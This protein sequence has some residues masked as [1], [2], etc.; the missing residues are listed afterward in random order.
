MPN[1]I[2]E[3]TIQFFNNLKCFISKKENITTIENVPKSFEELFGKTAPYHLSF[4]TQNKNTEFVGKGSP[5]LSAITKFLEKAGKTTLLKIDFSI[6]P[7]KE[8]K[9]TISLK[10]CEIENLTRK[11]KNNFF[12]RFTFMTTFRHLN[13][14]EQIINEIYVHDGEIVKGDLDGYT[15]IEGKK[16][17]V[18][19]KKIEQDYKIAH[20]FLKEILNEKTS[21]IKKVLE[22][23]I[24]NEIKRIRT[25]YE[26]IL[27][28]LGGDLSGTIKKIQENELSLRTADETETATLKTRLDRLRKSLLKMGNDDSRDRILKE[29]EFTIKDAMHKYSLNIDNKLINTTLIY[30]PIFHFNLFLK[31]DSSSR[32]VEMNYNPLTKTLNELNCESCNNKLTKINLCSAGHINCESC[33]EKCGECSKTFCKKC[34]K[35]ICSVCGKSLCRNCSTLCLGCG[36]HICKNHLRKDCVSGEEKCTNCLRACLRCHGLS[37]P[38]H[39]GEAIDGSKICKKCLGSEKRKGVMDK[40]FE[41]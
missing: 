40:I 7:I 13:D 23:K 31:G 39:F 12:S 2:E 26:N 37:H 25:H 19:E 3:F 18:S 24:E 17:E 33:L 27:G 1:Q 4:S 28:E 36:K 41:R 14:S 8:I 35:K 21:Q 22:S 29:Q 38:K 11:H 15:V 6:D 16:D 34:L 32:F 5:L 10:N 9:K 30:Y 20:N